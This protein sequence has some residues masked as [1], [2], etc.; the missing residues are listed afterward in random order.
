MHKVFVTGCGAIS[1]IGLSV[2][3]TYNSLLNMQTGIGKMQQIKTVHTDIPVGEV[4]LSN[5]QLREMASVSPGRFSR[6]VLLALVAAQEALD[7]AGIT[8]DK[9]LKTAVITGTTVSGL[10]RSEH[11]FHTFL[12]DNTQGEMENLKH[13]ECGT[14]TQDIADYF[15]FYDYIS[16][17]STACSSS[18]NAIALGHR[19]IAA[20]VVDRVLCGGEDALSNFTINGFNSMKI[21]DRKLCRPFDN[22]RAGLNLGEAAAFLVLESEDAMKSRNGE[23]IAQLSGWGNRCDAYHQTASSPEGRGPLLAMKEALKRATLQPNDID[24]VNV[25]GT[26][27]PNN[28]MTEGTALQTLFGDRIPPFSSTKLYTGHTLGAAGA[29]ESVISLLSL[30]YDTIFPT[31]NFATPM[32]KLPLQPV[33]S[34]TKKSLTHILTNSFGFGGNDTSLIFSKV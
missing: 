27:T 9:T 17:I 6:T 34:I 11:F 18:A 15:G 33:S 16:T 10:D 7:S 29:I 21:L 28:D 19:L 31:F 8:K 22:S 32:E 12:K 20:G 14:T 4:A 13:H 2:A 24:Y 23:P 1:S 25:H 3:E 26:G 5:E 30:Q